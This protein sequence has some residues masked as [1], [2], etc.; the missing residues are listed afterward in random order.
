MRWQEDGDA[1]SCLMEPGPDGRRLRQVDIGSDACA[2]R[3]SVDDWPFNPP[4][5]LYDPQ[6]ASLEISS[7]AFEAAWRAARHA[8]P[9]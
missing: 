6:Y 3:T 8:S 1:A 4:C 2:V 7:S 5:D 9:E